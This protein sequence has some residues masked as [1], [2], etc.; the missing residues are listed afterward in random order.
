MT[1]NVQRAVLGC[2][3]V[4]CVVLRF[5]GLDW[6]I[7]TLDGFAL[8]GRP[9]P[10]SEAG[11]HADA[12]AL[13]MAAQSL[14]DSLYPLHNYGG[15]DY[16]FTS[17]GTVFLYLNRV[18]AEVGSWFG[19]FEAFGPNVEDI[20][21]SRLSGRWVSALAS[22]IT[23]WLI[24]LL[25]KSV[26]GPVGGLLGAGL[27]AVMPMSVQASHLETVDGL[28]GLWFT[29]ALLPILRIASRPTMR[30]FVVAGL[31]IGLAVATKINGL[32]L[33]LPLGLAH[34]QGQQERLSPAVVLRAMM[35]RRLLGAIGIA[36]MVWVVLTPAAILRPTEYFSP[37]FAG[38]YHLLF[39]LRAASQGAVSHRGW[40]HMDGV[41]TYFYHIFRVFPLGLGWSVQVAVIAG[42][43]CLFRKRQPELVVVAVSLVVYYLLIA[44]LPDKP[45]R[46]FV[47]LCAFFCCLAAFPLTELFRSRKLMPVGLALVALLV[48]E[49]AFRSMALASV[50]SQPDSRVLAGKWARDN[51]PY[52]G[53]LMMERGHNSLQPVVAQN[54]VS[55][56]MAD[57]DQE[58][59]NALRPHLAKAG[60]YSAILESEFL[61]QADYLIISDDRLS[62]KRTRLAAADY[63]DKLFAGELGF[64][65]VEVFS[66]APSLLG[67]SPEGEFPDLNWTRYDHP[68]TF[69]FRRTGEPK[70]YANHPEL[71]IYQLR[72]WQDLRDVVKR[73]QK[74][75]DIAMFKRCLT[76]SYKERVGEREIA[77]LFLTFL[78]N[79]QSILSDSGQMRAIRE[80][81]AWHLNLD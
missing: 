9:V 72:T 67:I 80:G 34:L 14:S 26:M 61:S 22:A 81:S 40:L 55:T 29:A 42:L 49:P 4:I 65:L 20:N 38:P 73:S 19:D 60:H 1:Q 43:I 21:A 64:E 3:L 17:Y 75:K 56:L 71:S 74:E 7:R 79:P 15:A 32:F 28:L 68:S 33:L 16:F 2:V 59:T 53:K 70:L 8:D 57:M 27:A 58:F 76:G 52:A 37:V 11:F 48:V 69:M 47:P 39:S 12:D 63:Y 30:D 24:W 35:D 13:Y 31:L 50:Y 62:A 44:R 18:S 36:A 54:R 10:A 51:I 66:M 78:R 77:D 25:G 41:S 23:V 6:G 46:F 45:I 5:T